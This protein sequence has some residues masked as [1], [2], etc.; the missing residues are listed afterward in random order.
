V[1]GS[2]CN[3]QQKKGKNNNDEWES[4]PYMFSILAVIYFIGK[5]ILQHTWG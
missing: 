5:G 1:K 2:E 3:V 4:I